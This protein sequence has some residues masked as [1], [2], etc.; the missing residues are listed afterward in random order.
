MEIR[1]RTSSSL[2]AAALL[3]VSITI[4]AAIL[5]AMLIDTL[6]PTS[7]SASAPLH[8]T[9]AVYPELLALEFI[10]DCR[11]GSRPR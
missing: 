11:T 4:T 9:K 10:E 3:V 5:A 6:A 2:R 1:R 7:L 8:C